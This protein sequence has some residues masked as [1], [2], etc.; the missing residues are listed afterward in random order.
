MVHDDLKIQ[1][2]FLMF[3][4]RFFFKYRLQFNRLRNDCVLN[5]LTFISQIFVRAQFDY[6]PLD[7]ELIPCAQAG[8][9]F[10]TGDILQVSYLSLLPPFPLTHSLMCY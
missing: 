1:N 6:D 10:H 7:D 2:L 8:I 9:S 3:S 5:I 4:W